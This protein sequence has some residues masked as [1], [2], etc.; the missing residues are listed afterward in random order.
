MPLFFI[1]RNSTLTAATVAR[2][3]TIKLRQ[4]IFIRTVLGWVLRL[5]AASKQMYGGYRIQCSGRFARKQRAQ[6]WR[7][8]GGSFSFGT[9]LSRLEYATDFVTLKYSLCCVK[10]WLSLK[11][12][13]C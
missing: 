11:D 4:R 3:I 13:R 12:A 5:L 1:T 6:R 8:S 9:K 7:V 10:V 2:F